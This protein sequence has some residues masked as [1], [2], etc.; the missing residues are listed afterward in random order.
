MRTI[1]A[2]IISADEP[3]LERCLQ[4]VGSQTIPFS[5]IT[6]INNVSPES[7]AFNTGLAMV[8]DELVMK[9]DGDMILHNNAVETALKRIPEENGNAYVHNFILFDSFLKQNIRGCGV[10]VKS[11][12]RK[13]R[14]PNMLC[15]DV[16]VGHKLRKM[17]FGMERYTEVIGTHCEDPD[18]FQVFRRFYSMGVKHGKRYAWRY[19][20]RLYEDTKGPLYDLGM[21]AIEFGIE[22]KSYPTSHDVNFDRKMFEEF[23]GNENRNSHSKH[24]KF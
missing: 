2:L 9:I 6:H 7:T 22:K 12:F 15:D 5:N 19:L 4:S 13:V 16:W 10:M 8:K 11:I 1:E 18:E 14:Y 21:R 23:K 3:Q 17:G 24:G 20:S